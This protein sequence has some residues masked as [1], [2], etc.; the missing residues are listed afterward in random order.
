MFCIVIRID[1][2][3]IDVLIY[4]ISKNFKTYPFINKSK[5]K[6]VWILYFLCVTFFERDFLLKNDFHE[7]SS[8]IKY[9]KL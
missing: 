9:I 8:N 3:N 1:K 2:T 7:N 4:F 6:K 5:I